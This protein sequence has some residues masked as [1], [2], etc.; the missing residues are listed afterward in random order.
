MTVQ[1]PS[2]ADRGDRAD[3]ELGTW[4]TIAEGTALSRIEDLMQPGGALLD[5]IST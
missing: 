1:T 4:F 3:R 2:L 5:I